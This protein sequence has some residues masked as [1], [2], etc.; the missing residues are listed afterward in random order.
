[1]CIYKPNRTIP[2]KLSDVIVLIRMDCPEK[3]MGR[4]LGVYS[5]CPTFK[6]P[7]EEHHFTTFLTPFYHL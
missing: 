4:H 2:A 7:L 6:P 3:N 5:D 1:M